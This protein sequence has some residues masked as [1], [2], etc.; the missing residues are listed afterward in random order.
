MITVRFDRARLSNDFFAKTS[1]RGQFYGETFAR[2][3]E[4][5][6]AHSPCRLRPGS[7]SGDRFVAGV[8]EAAARIL[9]RG[10][11]PHGQGDRP[12]PQSSESLSFR[13]DLWQYERGLS[14]LTQAR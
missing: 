6:E 12:T 10:Q 5:H 8:S 11:G 13:R 9:G 14:K 4:Q 1:H 2:L 3:G 7:R